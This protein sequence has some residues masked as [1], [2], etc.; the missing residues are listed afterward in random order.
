M[1]WLVRRGGGG[2]GVVGGG[3][4]WLLGGVVV[5]WWWCLY[6]FIMGDYMV[7]LN[8]YIFYFLLSVNACF[9]LIFCGT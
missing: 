3:A 9:S 8:M 2:G 4:L 6:S 7:I 5:V 1:C